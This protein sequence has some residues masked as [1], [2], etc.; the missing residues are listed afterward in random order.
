MNFHVWYYTWH[1]I[2]AASGHTQSLAHTVCVQCKNCQRFS[3]I[4]CRFPI[5]LSYY[6]ALSKWAVETFCTSKQISVWT[7]CFHLPMQVVHFF[8]VVF[9]ILLGFG[10]AFTTCSCLSFM[11]AVS[12]SWTLSVLYCFFL[13]LLREP[14]VRQINVLVKKSV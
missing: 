14:H 6:V 9:V 3:F 4:L 7:K 8:V 2:K 10:S 12:F 1:D 5:F 13:I 11:S